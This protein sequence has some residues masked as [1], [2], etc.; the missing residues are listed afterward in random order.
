MAFSFSSEF[1]SKKIFNVDTSAYEYKKLEDLWKENSYIPDG[2]DEEVCDKIFPV[3]G[4]YLN[5]KSIY[6]PQPTVA[7]DEC[8]VNFP[9]FMYKTAVD[10]LADPRAIRAINDGK[11]GF[12][13]TRYEQK[14]FGKICYS[15]EWVDM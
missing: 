13:I 6:D 11:V 12:Q 15:A 2:L 9:A 14:R 1:N 3:C 4:L 5:E 8:Y 10:I 7:T